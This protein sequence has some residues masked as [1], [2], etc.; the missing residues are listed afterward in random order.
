MHLEKNVGFDVTS[1]EGR[2]TNIITN[3]LIQ[4]LEEATAEEL[5]TN[6]GYEYNPILSENVPKT[7]ANELVDGAVVSYYIPVN[8]E[9]LMYLMKGNYNIKL[10]NDIYID[11]SSAFM[12][13]EDGETVPIGNVTV[14]TYSATLDGSYNTI[15][16][17][18]GVFALNF[19]GSI[20]NTAFSGTN[21][22]KGTS[23]NILKTM[24]TGSKVSVVDLSVTSNNLG[25]AKTRNS[26]VEISDLNID[27]SAKNKLNDK[28]WMNMSATNDESEERLR[29]F[30]EY[31]DDLDVRG[32]YLEKNEA[33]KTVLVVDENGNEVSSQE[34]EWRN[35][36][37][38][39]YQLSKYA[40]LINDGDVF[41]LKVTELD[42]TSVFDLSGKIWHSLQTF[43]Y[44]IL[45]TSENTN[46]K[47]KIQNMYVEGTNNLGFISTYNS[48]E[49]KLFNL[50]FTNAKIV[51]TEATS[52]TT[53][54]ENIG[55]VVGN[56]TN[57]SASDISVKGIV[58]IDV[59]KANYV[60]TA[61]GKA[62]GELKNI[63]T[64]AAS[65]D[66]A[67]SK[68]KGLDFVG[69]IAGALTLPS[70]TASNIDNN[71]NISGR[72]FVGGLIGY[73]TGSNNPNIYLY[74][75]VVNDGV[76]TKVYHKNEGT[77]QG[78]NFVGGIV[79]YND[80]V[81]LNLPTNLGNVESNGYAVGGIA[82]YTSAQTLSAENGV[83]SGTKNRVA[84]NTL[85]TVDA[86]TE[87]CDLAKT[88]NEG[89]AEIALTGATYSN[90]TLKSGYFYGGIVGYLNG[91]DIRADVSNGDSNSR[92]NRNNATINATSFVGGIVGYNRAGSLFAKN[93]YLESVDN[94]L[95]GLRNYASVIGKTFVGGIA[96][97]N[98]N[99]EEK[100]ATV[101]D[102][103]V[104]I[105]GGSSVISGE[106]CVGGIVG[107]N[108]G[109]VWSVAAAGQLYGQT[110]NF[111]G[112]VGFNGS[113]AEVQYANSA[114]I[115]TISANDS[116]MSTTNGVTISNVSANYYVGG[117]V[118]HNLGSVKKSTYSKGGNGAAD[119]G[120]IK[121]AAESSLASAK[122]Q[123][124]YI[125]GLIGVNEGSLD[126]AYTD[127][128]TTIIQSTYEGI[129][130]SGTIHIGGL[131]GLNKANATIAD[132]Y[133]LAKIINRYNL[134]LQGGYNDTEIAAVGSEVAG[135]LVYENL[136]EIK[137]SYAT[138]CLFAKNSG[139]ISNDCYVM[140]LK[141]ISKT[142]N[143]VNEF[144]DKDVT[145][146]DVENYTVKDDSDNL[147]NYYRFVMT[148]F[149]LVDVEIVEVTVDPIAAKTMTY[150]A[151]SVKLKFESKDGK[152]SD[153]DW[154]VN[155]GEMTVSK[156]T[157]YFS[158]D[159]FNCECKRGEC[160][161][162]SR[163][164]CQGCYCILGEDVNIHSKTCV[165]KHEKLWLENFGVESSSNASVVN[166]FVRLMLRDV[167]FNLAFTGQTTPTNYDTKGNTDTVSPSVDNM[168]T[169]GF[170]GDGSMSNPFR[171]Y[172]VDDLDTLNR[173]LE[174]GNTFVG[175]TFKL[176]RDLDLN[177]A[178]LTIS[179][180]D[181]PFQGVFDGNGKTI[182]GNVLS[183]G[184][185]DNIGL[186]QVLASGG[187]IK[188]LILVDCVSSGN[189]NV[190]LVV[191]K[192]L[193]TIQDVQVYTSSASNQD[194]AVQGSENVGAICGLNLG[195]VNG[196]SIGARVK[197]S[198]NVGIV[199]G[200]N[201]NGRVSAC[202]T[203]NTRIELSSTNIDVSSFATA[204]D[205]VGGIVGY[206]SGVGTIAECSNAGE[207]NTNGYGGGIVGLSDAKVISS[208]YHAISD[209]I[210]SGALSGNGKLGQLA[211]KIADPAN[212]VLL[213]SNVKA[214]GEASSSVQNCYVVDGSNSVLYQNNALKTE[215]YKNFNF[216]SVWG[217]TP[218]QLDTSTNK[219]SYPLLKSGEY[220]YPKLRNLRSSK[221]LVAVEGGYFVNQYFNVNSY[222]SQTPTLYIESQYQF[223]VFINYFLGELVAQDIYNPLA[224][225][226]PRC[227][228]KL[229][230]SVKA[231]A[232]YTNSGVTFKLYKSALSNMSASNKPSVYKD[233]QSYS[234]WVA[235]PE[236]RNKNIDFSGITIS[237]SNFND[238]YI[239][240]N[241]QG[242]TTSGF[243]SSFD[244]DNLN[245][246]GEM[247]HS[248]YAISNLNLTF[249][250]ATGGLYFGGIVGYLGNANIKNCKVSYTGTAQIKYVGAY[251]A[252]TYGGAIAGFIKKKA[253]GDNTY[254]E[255]SGCSHTGFSESTFDGYN[256]INL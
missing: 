157:L 141:T 187:Q 221:E 177:G 61:F 237:I 1:V 66:V 149:T 232:Q 18:K 224:S 172:S 171:I 102:S 198:K 41:E 27:S 56:F 13:G 192:N 225:G 247:E 249:K 93:V 214:L 184:A 183:G 199:V 212:N 201:S 73:S 167:V 144:G 46:E 131:V 85:I 60:G 148:K 169:T 75:Q 231:N 209:V 74:E 31:W 241:T 11:S 256:T 122:M 71:Y 129:S 19:G 159:V 155:I 185:N 222:T 215:V 34:K 143:Q 175:K 86:Q 181:Y 147:D 164:C 151:Q 170:M 37:K 113:D 223:E 213:T 255:I 160:D 229:L 103:V 150:K 10:E 81:T 153:T 35:S 51:N 163:G 88:L 165:H 68:V 52:E 250:S 23:S 38:D 26:N 119:A 216:D 70:K 92:L 25:L 196:C 110:A 12:K 208:D 204:S 36:I 220:N 189:N 254:G 176:M 5:A 195:S 63:S 162:L 174:F 30:V 173:Q 190:G 137:S 45:S 112:I 168:P 89:F 146:V 21:D 179:S 48:P 79:G 203:L 140:E 235:M 9:T 57:G 107:A 135:G 65:E 117:I 166:D 62:Y 121:F 90:D 101:K 139:T 188:N 83:S 191:G 64:V 108:Y 114:M 248:N 2:T 210:N 133:S 116:S 218:T 128:N 15:Y 243:I 97:I 130:L 40:R 226:E 242:W 69:G 59:P 124:I 39:S 193:G 234:D 145:K 228:E 132:C 76:A 47:A 180:A 77:V 32:V 98:V 120:T 236:I 202:E 54:F 219:Y 205:N 217:M 126:E 211:G 156:S 142:I 96:G 115:M 194:Y 82:G 50:E 136:G 55:V 104:D 20:I 207:V 49:G 134:K 95:L 105:S 200:T 252:S 158:A 6:Y 4:N 227:D 99:V 94:S 42:H 154:L 138:Y 53:R 8:T 244:G 239:A 7:R 16:G 29:A 109:Q 197:G 127:A 58:N 17:V 118:G 178:S 125:G 186:F 80:A 44:S 14:D 43:E 100:L 91:T 161:C 233:S 246:K 152:Y 106:Y 238:K 24:Q 3:E 87:Q 28:L 230:S 245:S 206:N 33:T 72:D 84:V 67:K 78:R 251:G 240:N 123:N 253:D 111:G 22:Y 182:K